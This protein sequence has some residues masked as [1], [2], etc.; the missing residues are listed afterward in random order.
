MST[1][2]TRLDKLEARRLHR[3]N[4]TAEH[5]EKIKAAA[6]EL[7]PELL[8]RLRTERK[9]HIKKYCGGIHVQAMWPTIMKNYRRYENDKNGVGLF[10]LEGADP[11]DYNLFN[12][13]PQMTAR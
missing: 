6:G 3:S 1:L 2:K 9:A 13:L 7:T 10:D 8:H 5:F 4:I 11:A 12:E